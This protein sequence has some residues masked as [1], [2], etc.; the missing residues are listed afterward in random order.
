MSRFNNMSAKF[1]LGPTKQFGR[2][3]W[4]CTCP[5]LM[6]FSRRPVLAPFPARTRP[7]QFTNHVSFPQRI[8]LERVIS[9]RSTITAFPRNRGPKR[10][11]IGPD[12]N[13]VI[14]YRRRKPTY[15]Q[16]EISYLTR[17]ETLNLTPPSSESSCR[18]RLCGQT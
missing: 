3:S 18:V 4:P 16:N 11:K 9:R 14:V 1:F 5:Y 2:N 13:T 10:R 8:S 15:E 12:G 7:R 17:S 6:A